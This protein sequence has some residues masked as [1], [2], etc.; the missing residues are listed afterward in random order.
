[1]HIFHGYINLPIICT[2]GNL[3]FSSELCKKYQCRGPTSPNLIESE[4]LRVRL[5]HQYF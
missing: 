2:S 4:T 5:E 3:G 1:M